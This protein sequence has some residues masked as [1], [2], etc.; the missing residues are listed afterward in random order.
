MRKMTPKWLEASK[1][2]GKKNL[3]EAF[4]HAANILPLG[5]NFTVLI[6]LKFQTRNG[7]K[8]FG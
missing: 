7:S 5:Q 6:F 3:H 1:A 8:T 2:I 4:N